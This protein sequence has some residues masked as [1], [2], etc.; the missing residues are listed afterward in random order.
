MLNLGRSVYR[1]QPDTDRDLPVIV[2]IQVVLEID[3]GYGFGKLFK[4]CGGRA[5]AGIIN[6]FTAC[7]ACSN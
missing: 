2:A 3:P 1:Y 5:M 7:I 6:E 4:H